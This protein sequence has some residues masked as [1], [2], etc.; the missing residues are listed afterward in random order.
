MNEQTKAYNVKPED[1]DKF[2]KDMKAKG[3]YLRQRM[4]SYPIGFTFLL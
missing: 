4:K 2:I 3:W 1:A